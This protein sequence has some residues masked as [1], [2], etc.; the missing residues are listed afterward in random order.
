MRKSASTDS[1]LQQRAFTDLV[2]FPKYFTNKNINLYYSNTVRNQ[3][4][5]IRLEWKRHIQ[6]V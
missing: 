5:I 2:I 3:Y 4:K 1:L 6:N